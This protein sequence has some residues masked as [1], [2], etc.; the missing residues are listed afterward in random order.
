M[1]SVAGLACVLAALAATAH[2][3]QRVESIAVGTSP[4]AALVDPTDGKLVVAQADSRTGAGSV[5]RMD[6]DGRTTIIALPQVPTRIALQP[7][8]HR[9][10]MLS[11][12]GDQASILDLDTGST[13]TVRTGRG[14]VAAVLSE[15]S[16]AFVIGAGANGDGSA[17]MVDLRTAA[18]R[19]VAWTGF[20]PD[21]GVASRDAATLYMI[22]SAQGHASLQAF[23]VA[24]RRLSGDAL[25]LEMAPSD[26]AWSAG[27]LAVLGIAGT[28]SPR[29]TLR[30]F[31]ATLTSWQSLDLGP[32]ERGDV[33]PRLESDGQGR[34]W[35]MDPGTAKVWMVE[36]DVGSARAIDLESPPAAMAWNRVTATLLVAL[37]NGQAAVL[38]ASGLR[39]DTLPLTRAAT[40]DAAMSISIDGASGDA[41]V[42]NAAEATIARLPREAGA[43][44]PFNLTDLWLNPADPGWGVFIDQQGTTAFG[45]LFIHTA[46]GDPTW[47]VMSNGTRQPDGSFSGLLYRTQG[48]GS[49]TGVVALPAGLMRISPSADGKASL[50]T[51]VDGLS[52]TQIVERFALGNAPRTCGWALAGDKS[53]TN[54]TGLWSNPTDPGW[55]IAVAQRGSAAFAVLFTYDE[56][57]R[58]TWMVM[59]N[60][61]L[62]SKGA[63]SGD[64]YRASRTRVESSGTMT[65]RLQGAAEGSI[66]YRIDGTQF[67]SPVLRQSVGKL[68]SRCEP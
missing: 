16:A 12:T 32:T 27:E 40:G 66:G 15:T 68:L 24:T 61:R 10:L 60:G 7:A 26:L 65:L 52:Q 46:R 67:R 39:L 6:R 43:D 8:L 41:Y 14:A 13:K 23:D 33:A 30:V 64:L 17:T 38:S 59:S 34:L 11:P 25:P 56:Q 31:D 5:M 20:R 53:V 18:A 42:L 37:R 21:A 62:A 2:G 28:T 1:K 9:L 36:S 4:V 35:A 51:V 44:A 57:N 58:P 54:A 48:G 22:G 3:A 49:R 50:T 63:F 45:A 47:L 55:G 19:T 29:L